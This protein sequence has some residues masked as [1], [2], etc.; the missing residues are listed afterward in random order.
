MR[1]FPVPGRLD[2]KSGDAAANKGA[3]TG[4]MN[5]VK[6]FSKPFKPSH[7]RI[8]R[9]RADGLRQWLPVV[10]L[11]TLLTTGMGVMAECST[12]GGPIGEDGYALTD[13]CGHHQR[14]CHLH[15]SI[16]PGPKTG[17]LH[18]PLPTPSD[19]LI[20]RWSLPL[21][22]ETDLPDLDPVTIKTK[23]SLAVFIPE[24]GPMLRPVSE[25][26]QLFTPL[27]LAHQ[28]LIC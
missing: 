23:Y 27:Y 28:S 16:H 17:C 21:S 14:C 18:A 26:Q 3:V 13:A 10:T 19:Y 22:A 1:L 15:Q 12:V 11:L 8:R 9:R 6:S 25:R 5:T 24:A 20:D 4:R 7:A 2:D